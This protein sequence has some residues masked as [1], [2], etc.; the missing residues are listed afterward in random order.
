MSKNI[1]KIFYINLDKREDRKDEIE[2]EL[3]TY[4]LFD[5]A[6][7]I[8]AIETPGQGIL[9]CI[10]YYLNTNNTLYICYPINKIIFV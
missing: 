1:T 9:R 10:S 6:E 7:R 4:D 2:T 3:R 5:N 8:Q